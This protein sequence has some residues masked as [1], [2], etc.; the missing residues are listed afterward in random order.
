MYLDLHSLFMGSFKSDL[1][2]V[3]CV[4]SLIFLQSWGN[5]DTHTL[6]HNT[7]IHA[8]SYA[9]HIHSHAHSHAH[10]IITH[11]SHHTR[12]TQ[13]PVGTK[14][15]GIRLPCANGLARANTAIAIKGI[16]INYWGAESVSVSLPVCYVHVNQGLIT[17][18]SHPSLT[19]S[20]NSMG[21]Q[22]RISL[23]CS[24][25]SEI[26]TLQFLERD[27]L[28]SDFPSSLSSCWS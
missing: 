4:H 14:H 1:S 23:L 19:G 16:C 27:S 3:Q 26:K 11:T 17:S 2:H 8:Y 28:I 22:E 9:Q 18:D 6:I 5:K 13:H 10:C 21:R 7:H 20:W 12:A 25:H 24:L 15:H